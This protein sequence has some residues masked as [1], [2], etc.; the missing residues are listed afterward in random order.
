[1]TTEKNANTSLY[2]PEEIKAKLRIRGALYGHSISSQILDAIE[3]Y[4][5][6]MK[7]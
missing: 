6:T 4:L 3:L 1:M 5:R 2:I 7:D